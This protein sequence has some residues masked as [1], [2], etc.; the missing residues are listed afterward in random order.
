M[1][2]QF[3]SIFSSCILIRTHH[4]HHTFIMDIQQLLHYLNITPWLYNR[5]YDEHRVK[6]LIQQFNNHQYIPFFLHLATIQQNE[7]VEH[8][9]S[10]TFNKI[11]TVCYDGGHRLELLRYIYSQQPDIQLKCMIDI[12]FNVTH[13]E[14]YNE[15]ENINKNVQV[16]SSY[17]IEHNK[18]LEQEL[19]QETTNTDIELQTLR[20][21]QQQQILQQTISL[22]VEEYIK[23]FPKFISP[24]ERY[25]A[26]NFNRDCFCNQLHIIYKQFTEDNE[27]NIQHKFENPI[28]FLEELKQLLVDLNTC[29]SKQQ[30]CKSHSS[31]RDSLVKKCKQY[32]LWLFMDRTL[33]FSHLRQ[34]YIHKQTN[35]KYK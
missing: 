27:L 15:F 5:H 14:I 12:M 35:K 22:I 32:N 1:S 28:A 7:P 31:Y 24:S 10:S 8:I 30:L 33:Q 29:Y 11:D 18:E 13:Q 16:P 17:F 23:Q 21:L 4:K 25:Y 34:L 9:S 19:E 20:E 3:P 2:I 6:T 26:P